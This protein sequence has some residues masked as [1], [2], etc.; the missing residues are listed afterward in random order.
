MFL[1][2]SHRA[3]H[4]RPCIYDVILLTTHAQ[5]RNSQWKRRSDSRPRI[6]EQASIR[7]IHWC[8]QP[9]QS[10]SDT[11]GQVQICRKS[12]SLHR[13]MLFDWLR[14]KLSLLGSQN[15]RPLLRLRGKYWQ[16]RTRAPGPRCPAYSQHQTPCYLISSGP[17][18]RCPGWASTRH[19]ITESQETLARWLVTAGKIISHFH[20]CR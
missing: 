19:L 17:E 3:Q 5:K 11:L 20:C 16:A 6:V 12:R 1:I 14:L 13:L 9:L 7:K 4:E 18:P 2:L 15:T 8:F 10:T